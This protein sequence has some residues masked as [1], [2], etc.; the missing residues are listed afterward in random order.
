[1]ER[2]AQIFP[3]L[4]AA[5]VERIRAVGRPLTVPAG[6]VLIELGEQ[7]TR[8]FLVL[9]GGIEILVPMVSAERLLVV[10]GPGQFTGEV[11][12]LSARRSLARARTVAPSDLIVLDHD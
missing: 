10:Y 6:E 2:E 4:T 9:R 8:F 1:M 7:N 5:Q 3:T 12:M 11:N